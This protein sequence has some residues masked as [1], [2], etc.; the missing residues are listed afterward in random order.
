MRSEFIAA[1]A[2]DLHLHHSRQKQKKHSTR[3]KALNSNNTGFL[4]DYF[5]AILATTTANKS[6]QSYNKSQVCCV[7]YDRLLKSPTC[8]SLAVWPHVMQE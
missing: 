6:P 3:V 2:R 4:P 7:Q 5:A 1:Q 8:Y